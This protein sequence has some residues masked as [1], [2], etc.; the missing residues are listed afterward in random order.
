MSSTVKRP[1][2]SVVPH[3]TPGFTDQQNPVND[4]KMNAPI[5]YHGHGQHV[6]AAT[7]IAEVSPVL[8]IST[9]QE[10]TV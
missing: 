2:R 4:Y 5:M 6:T 10:L 1:V 9:S 3:T 8:H 7:A